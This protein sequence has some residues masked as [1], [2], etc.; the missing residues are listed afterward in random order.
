MKAKK[1][2]YIERK[3]STPSSI[4]FAHSF[5]LLFLPTYNLPSIPP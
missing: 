5:A 1:K 3:Q 2:K 4:T